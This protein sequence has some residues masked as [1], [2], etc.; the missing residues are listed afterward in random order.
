MDYSRFV[1]NC[2]KLFDN[3][4]QN[5]K[6]KNSVHFCG[7]LARV[8]VS[9]ASTGGWDSVVTREADTEVTKERASRNNTYLVTKKA[10]EAKVVIMVMEAEVPDSGSEDTAVD[11]A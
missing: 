3:G 6:H 7:T 1:Q 8:I 11:T 5:W 9:M 10:T 4:V 2:Y